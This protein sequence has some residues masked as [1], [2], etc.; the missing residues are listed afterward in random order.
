MV[1][2]F[3]GRL[4]LIA[5]HNIMIFSHVNMIFLAFCNVFGMNSQKNITFCPK[6]NFEIFRKKKSKKWQGVPKAKFRFLAGKSHLLEMTLFDNLKHADSISVGF[7][8]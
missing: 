7:T 8:R 2:D 1:P 4:T 6:K 3:F 5:G